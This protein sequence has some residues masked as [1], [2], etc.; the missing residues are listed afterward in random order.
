MARKTTECGGGDK[1]KQGGNL[2]LNVLWEK[3]KP[4]E[5]W[6]PHNVSSKELSDDRVAMV[7]ARA[8]W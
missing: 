2:F 5:L 6:L 3:L 4:S 1:R 7:A 8:W